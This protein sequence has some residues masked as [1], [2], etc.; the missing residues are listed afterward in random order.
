VLFL[1]IRR[2]KQYLG[3]WRDRLVASSPKFLLEKLKKEL[4]K[5]SN[6]LL[7]SYI[8]YNNSR[9][10]RVRAMTA[11][12]VALNPIAILERGYSITRTVP[13]ARMVKD[14]RTVSLNQKVEVLIARGRLLCRIKGK[15]TDVKKEDLRTSHEAT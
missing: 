12:L 13:D 4:E 10:I 11:K 3:F 2:D 9:Q 14:A 1:R 6:N 5:N 8:I 7:K 15:S